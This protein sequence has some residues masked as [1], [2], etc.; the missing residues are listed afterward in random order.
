MKE[1]FVNF[2]GGAEGVFTYISLGKI[3]AKIF[4]SVLFIFLVRVI[5]RLACSFIHKWIDKGKSENIRRRKTLILLLESITK[6]TL[7]FIAIIAIFSI[8]GV[9]VTSLLAGAGI[10]GLAIGF[11]AQ[12]LVEDVISGF[13]ILIEDQFAVGDFVEIAGKTGIVQEIGFRTTIIRN[14]AGEIYVIPNGEIRQVTNYSVAEDLRVMV[15]VTIPYEENPGRAIAELEKLCAMVKEEKEDII[16][17]GPSV[18]G[19]QEL[20]TNGVVLRL[21]VRAKPMQHWGI[22]RYLRQ[23]IK[24]HFDAVGI[25]IAY[26]HLVLLSNSLSGKED[27]TQSTYSE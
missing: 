14:T 12:K 13:F 9:P 26:P 11:G 24:E 4:Y 1:F 19:V 21:M 20:S 7:Y 16:T 22:G 18:L 2:I 8:F 5:N 25:K 23:R 17:S 6:Y 27:L 10:L 15:D 3:I